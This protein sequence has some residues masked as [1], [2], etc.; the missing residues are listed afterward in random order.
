[1]FLVV[2][3]EGCL[4]FADEVLLCILAIMTSTILEAILGAIIILRQSGRAFHGCHRSE[5]SNGAISST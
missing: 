3:T 2:K 4:C 5:D 1:M